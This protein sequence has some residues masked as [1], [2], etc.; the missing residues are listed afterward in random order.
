[1]EE[2]SLV[3]AE[4]A[5]A[6]KIELLA[7]CSIRSQDAQRIAGV[8]SIKRHIADAATQRHEVL[9]GEVRS[10]ETVE[11]LRLVALASSCLRVEEVSGIHI[12]RKVHWLSA[13]AGKNVSIKLLDAE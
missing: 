12:R 10:A 6:E 13:G 1:S 7:P 8:A 9:T 5:A 3:P 4:L 11:F 2:F